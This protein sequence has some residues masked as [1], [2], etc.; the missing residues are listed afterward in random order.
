MA[1]H[2]RDAEIENC[3]KQMSQMEL[4]SI[5]Q[6]AVYEIMLVDACTLLGAWFKKD[7]ID[8]I[9]KIAPVS[10][11]LAQWWAN[12]REKTT[13]RVLAERVEAEE[14]RQQARERGGAP[15]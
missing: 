14:A 15:N 3:L 10:N 6:A 13:A 5:T 7:G 2:D 8:P 1:D 4:W 11:A 9:E 12:A